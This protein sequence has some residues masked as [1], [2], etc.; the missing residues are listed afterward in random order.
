MPLRILT[1]MR[2]YILAYV[3][4]LITQLK[5]EHAYENMY[6]HSSE[7][8]RSI[9]LPMDILLLVRGRSQ[10]CANMY[11]IKFY[12]TKPTMVNGAEV[13]CQQ[14]AQEGF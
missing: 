1:L 6:F 14:K 11:S 9:N 2:N 12:S 5:M 13:I 7:Q 4:N 3:S 8:K 10:C